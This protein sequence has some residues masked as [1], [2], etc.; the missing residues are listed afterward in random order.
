MEAGCAA[1]AGVKSVNPETEVCVVPVADGGE[2]TLEALSGRPDFENMICRVADPMG[3]PIDAVYKING[4]K[5]IIELAQASGLSLVAVSERN[6]LEAS[7]YGTGELI[8]D[9]LKRGCREILI[10]IGGSATNDAGVGL[11]QAL[12]YRFLDADGCEVGRGACEAGRI[13]AIDASFVMQEIKD[14]SFTVACDVKNPLVGAEGASVVY[15]PQKGADK[16]MVNFLDKILTSVASVAGDFLG[17]DYSGLPGAGAAGG[18]GF[19]LLAFLNARLCAGIDLVLDAVGFDNSLSNADL[20]ITGEGCL[21]KQ[22]CMG[23]VAHGILNRALCNSVP[24]IAIGGMIENNAVEA[25]MKSGFK[26]IFPIVDRPMTLEEAM[27]PE[28]AIRNIER[29]VAQITRTLS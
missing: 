22:T 26:A 1:A 21:D 25:L 15:G 14:A 23:K 12:G 27:A 9:A 8:A 10:C 20:V 17:K 4:D 13:R 2:G 16:E 3:R 7:S 18:V 6:P 19:A 28:T 5:A 29:T 24:V 11:L